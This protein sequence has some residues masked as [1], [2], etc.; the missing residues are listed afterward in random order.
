MSYPSTPIAQ[1]ILRWTLF[2]LLLVVS[3]GWAL[4]SVLARSQ[5]MKP[6]E[7]TASAWAAMAP[8]TETKA[9]VSIDEVSGT[10]LHATILE[11]ESDTV[12]LKPST[13]GPKVTAILSTETSVA[14]GKAEDIVPGAIVQVAGTLDDCHVLRTTQVVILTG[15]VHLRKES[16]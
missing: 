11:R 13:P 8:G 14:M 12:Y 1:P 3:A 10:T 15:Y 2:L 9:V 16:R 7:T 5:Q 6:A 4:R